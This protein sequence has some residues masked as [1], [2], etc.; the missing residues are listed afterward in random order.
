MVTYDHA[1]MLL[2]N[3]SHFYWQSL[4]EQLGI[5]T[6]CPIVRLSKKSDNMQDLAIAYAYCEENI[7]VFN[8]QF[9]KRNVKVITTEI[10]LH[11][12]A[13][14]AAYAIDGCD[15]HGKTWR[16]VMKRLGLKCKTHYK[17]TR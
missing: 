7:L 4:R 3:H 12:L 13:H 9:L 11:E 6:L 15:N 10:L 17:I 14:F 5:T 2:E 16:Q 8:K 1:L